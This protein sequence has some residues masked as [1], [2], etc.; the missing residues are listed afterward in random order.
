MNLPLNLTV[1]SISQEKPALKIIENNDYGLDHENAQSIAID[2]GQ[3]SKV[4]ILNNNLDKIRLKNGASVKM[5]QIK[6]N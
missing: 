1:Q 3:G 5:E 6:S 2:K 4:I